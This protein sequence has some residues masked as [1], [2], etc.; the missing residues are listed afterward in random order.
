MHKKSVKVYLTE[1]YVDGKCWQGPE[2]VAQSTSEAE[3]KLLGMEAEVI[4]TKKFSVTEIS[5][6]QPGSLMVEIEDFDE[7]TLGIV[8][9]AL[10]EVINE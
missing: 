10:T 9:T 2:I 6:G 7:D 3:M 4:G 5:G 1:L 8:A